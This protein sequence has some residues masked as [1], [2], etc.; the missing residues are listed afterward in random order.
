MFIATVKQHIRVPTVIVSLNYSKVPKREPKLTSAAIMERDNHT[1]QVT[2]IKLP[3][4]KLNIDHI[5]PKSK[6]GVNDW[7][8][9]VSMSKEINSKKGNKTLEEAGLKLIKQPRKP[10]AIPICATIKDIRHYT[11]KH[12]IIG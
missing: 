11:W 3:K 9:M 7:K 6:G 2:G 12:F 5:I 10:N 4:H 8:N 1:C